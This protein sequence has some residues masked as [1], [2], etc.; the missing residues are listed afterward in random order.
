MTK[1]LGEQ[2]RRFIPNID[3]HNRLSQERIAEKLDIDPTQLSRALSGSR[4]FGIES[5]V[6]V[7]ERLLVPND[8]LAEF[9]LHSSSY[10]PEVIARALARYEQL[11]QLADLEPNQAA[12]L[13]RDNEGPIRRA[14]TFYIAG[15]NTT[16]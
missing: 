12:L 11:Q 5:G 14:H 9:L 6:R 4:G 2:L 13:I 15:N 7:S 8:Q 1:G 10:P 3:P 16:K